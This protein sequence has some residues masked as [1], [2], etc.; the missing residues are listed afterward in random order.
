MNEIR[1]TLPTC[2]EFIRWM[3]VVFGAM[4]D[5]MVPLG[6]IC[7]SEGRE[8]TRHSETVLLIWMRAERSFV[9]FVVGRGREEVVLSLTVDLAIEALG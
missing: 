4:P 9:A 1:G 8:S 6:R 7:R 2:E 3:V 5:R